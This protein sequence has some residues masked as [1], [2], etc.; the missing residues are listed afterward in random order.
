MKQRSL[1][2]ESWQVG[3]PEFIPFRKRQR[4]FSSSRH[5][6]HDL[7]LTIDECEDKFWAVQRHG[8]ASA[9]TDPSHKG[10][11]RISSLQASCD[12]ESTPHPVLRQFSTP[13]VPHEQLLP[14]S[15]SRW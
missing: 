11:L 2:H 10:I 8:R 13:S 7:P 12:H 14:N 15:L 9:T 5:L 1:T 4:I 3:P 6:T